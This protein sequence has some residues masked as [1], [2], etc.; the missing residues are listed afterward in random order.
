MNKKSTTTQVCNLYYENTFPSNDWSIVHGT[1][2]N[3]MYIFYKEI[4]SYF[5]L[6]YFLSYSSF[7]WTYQKPTT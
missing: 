6:F 1:V 7:E 4:Y 3:H 5:H 2:S